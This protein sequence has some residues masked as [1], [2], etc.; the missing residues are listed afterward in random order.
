[1]PAERRLVMLEKYI[2][3][4][5]MVCGEAFNDSDD[6]VVCPDCGTPYHRACWQ[7]KGSCINTE[8]HTTGQIWQ[9]E[10]EEPAQEMIRCV[11]CGT[12]NPS[13]MHFCGQCGLPLN[14][15]EGDIPRPFNSETVS[16]DAGNENNSFQNMDQSP[17]GIFSSP[18]PGQ[19]I[20]LTAQSDIGGVKL[21]DFMEYAGRSSFSLI[22]SFIRFAATKGKVSFNLAAFFF[23]EF[24]MFY[25]KMNKKGVLILALTFILS[26]PSLLY[27]GQTGTMGMVLF[28]T[29]IN[30]KS[31]EFIMVTNACSIISM[32]MSVICGLYANYWYYSKAKKEIV[33]IRAEESLDDK[34][35]VKR[36]RSRGGTSVPAV[37][38]AIVTEML[39]SLMFWLALSIVF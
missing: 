6:M 15:N 9:P 23:P 29:A 16:P 25:R 32:V 12:D 28:H 18:V 27:Y 7:E 35:A 39:L 5:C 14:S 8:L 17:M 31:N 30:V 19:T 20:K 24:Y 33:S 13:T 38:G 1:M 3:E 37:V 36:I 34:E 21:G 2:G 11:R 4:K 10:I 22:A 26:L